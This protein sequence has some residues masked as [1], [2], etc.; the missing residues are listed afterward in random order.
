MR[1]SKQVTLNLQAVCN[2]AMQQTVE[3]THTHFFLVKISVF[4]RP[5]SVTY[6]SFHV[7]VLN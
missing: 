5:N 4:S 1:F 6:S 2:C 7:S 3:D